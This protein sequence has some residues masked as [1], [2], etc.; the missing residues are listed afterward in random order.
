MTPIVQALRSLL[1]SDHPERAVPWS[2]TLL[3]D[4]ERRDAPGWAAVFA[5]LHAQ[6]L[7]RIGDLAEARAYASRA[8]SALPE[9][10]GGALPYAA[11]A[12]LIRAHSAMGHYTEASRLCDRP[13]PAALLDSLDGLAFLHARGLH[14][15]TGNQP[16]AALT[17]FLTIG[18]IMQAQG[19]DR[20]ACLPWRTDAAQAL[21]RL[22]KSQQAERLVL[23]QLALPDARRPWVRGVSLHQRALTNGSARQRV[24]LLE[25]AVNELHRSGDRLATARAMADLGRARQ[26]EAGA[27]AKGTATIRAAWNL[28]KECGAT[29]LCKEI[30]PDA[31]LSEPAPDHAER[32]GPERLES[33]LSSSEQRVATLAAQGLTNREI[34]AKLYLTVSTV[35]QHLTKVYRKLQISGRGDLPFDLSPDGPPTTAGQLVRGD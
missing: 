32:P 2:R 8:L 20:P 16:Q 35:E 17:D 13:V 9:R 1:L 15:L 21:L 4:A 11:T 33:R 30:L 7:L 10:S 5:T 3:E 23:Q 25:Q 14:H 34:S 18:R 6:A 27:P 22:G 29:A 24:S 28:A 31:P 12:V 19:I 26:S